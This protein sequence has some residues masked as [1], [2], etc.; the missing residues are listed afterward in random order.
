MRVGG[1]PILT[2]PAAIWSLA[3]LQQC[4]RPP[5][6][7]MIRWNVHGAQAGDEPAETARGCRLIQAVGQGSQ[8]ALRQVVLSQAIPC[9][10]GKPVRVQKCWHL[11]ALVEVRGQ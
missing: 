3:G 10:G 9:S 4:E 11:A 5:N 7:C 2:R 6:D 1:W 8:H